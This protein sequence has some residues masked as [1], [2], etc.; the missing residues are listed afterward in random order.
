MPE[1]ISACIVNTDSKIGT[2]RVEWR[3]PRAGTYTFVIS[4]KRGIKEHPERLLT[5]HLDALPD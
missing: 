1:G 2:L 4:A 5:F 3:V